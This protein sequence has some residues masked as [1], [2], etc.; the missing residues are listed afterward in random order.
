MNREG[1]SML[2]KNLCALRKRKGLTQEALAKAAGIRP[3]TIYKY[4]KGIVKN[5]PFERIEALASALET[6]P[7]RLLGWEECK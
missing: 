6:T 7:S 3:Q 4:E 5:I 1:E 2:D